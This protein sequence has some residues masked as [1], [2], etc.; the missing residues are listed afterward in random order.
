MESNICKSC[1]F[2]LDV[3]SKVYCQPCLKI[4]SD[5]AYVYSREVMDYLFINCGFKY[6]CSGFGL[7][8]KNRFWVFERTPEYI[9]ALKK[10][11]SETRQK[12]SK[13]IEIKQQIEA[14]N[15]QLKELDV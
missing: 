5:Y 9:E 3:N 7:R 6:I 11:T 15:K 13:K 8:N 14:L 4:K 12:A 1:G 10:F 2:T